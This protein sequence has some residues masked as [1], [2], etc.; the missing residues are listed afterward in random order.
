MDEE[1]GVDT[2]DAGADGSLDG[3][4]VRFTG[5]VVRSCWRGGFLEPMEGVPAP[6]SR[7]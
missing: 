2:R 3:L 5:S 6:E 4:E 7:P 1:D